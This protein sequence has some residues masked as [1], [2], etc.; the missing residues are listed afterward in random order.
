MPGISFSEE[1]FKAKMQLPAAWY[2]GVLKSAAEKAGKSNPDSITH[3][4]EF[5][6]EEGDAKGVKAM[7]FCNDGVASQMGDLV[8]LFRCFIP[9]LEKGKTYD[10]KDLVGRPIR[11][12]AFYNP[13]MNMNMVKDFM[14]SKRVVQ[15]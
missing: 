7:M 8:N 1:D 3:H 2:E 10:A 5:S 14:P 6:I 11:I 9:K 13:D 15:S 12:Y 4:L